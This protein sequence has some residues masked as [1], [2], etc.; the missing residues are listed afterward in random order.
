MLAHALRDFLRHPAIQHVLVVVH[1]D[2]LARYRATVSADGSQ[3]A[4]P[5][6]GGATRQISV[7]NGLEALAALAPDRVLIHDAARPFV[8]AG[9]VDRV[10]AALDAH[11]GAVAASR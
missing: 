5:C 3:A 1:G 4:R 7:R 9:V 11:T 6:L 10:L 8:D 2:D